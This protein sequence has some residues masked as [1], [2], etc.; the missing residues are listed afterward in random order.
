MVGVFAE[1]DL[2]L[3]EVVLGGGVTGWERC[4]AVRRRWVGIGGDLWRLV[5]HASRE[6]WG[7]AGGDLGRIGTW[8][9]QEEMAGFGDGDGAGGVWIGEEG[10]S[11]RKKTTK[12]VEWSGVEEEL[13]WW[14]SHKQ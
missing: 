6:G 3:D 9:R 2:D 14:P 12:Q 11:G 10:G 1:P 13:W 5:L 4:G 7:E 8:D